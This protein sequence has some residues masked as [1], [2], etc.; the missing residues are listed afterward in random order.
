MAFAAAPG[1]A[2]FSYL[3]S[4]ELTNPVAIVLHVRRLNDALFEPFSAQQIK[5]AANRVAG[6]M[7]LFMPRLCNPVRFVEMRGRDLS[8]ENGVVTSLPLAH[9]GGI[10]TT[11]LPPN[12]AYLVQWRTGKAGRGANGRSYVPGV[13]ENGTNNAGF[14]DAAEVNVWLAICQ[15]VLAFLAAPTDATHLGA[16]L[17]LSVLHGPK[18]SP[19]TRSADKVTAGRLSALVATQRRRLPPRPG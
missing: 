16:P 11:M 6:A 18:G 19:Q 12:V 3:G 2:Q 13:P 4:V 15:D 7:L 1:V 17:E 5:D 14:V 10:A 9:Q 8:L